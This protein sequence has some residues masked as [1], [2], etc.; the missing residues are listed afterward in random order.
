MSKKKKEHYVPQGY[1][2]NWCI[3]GSKQVNVFDKEKDEIRTNSIEDIASENYFYDLNLEG[4][5]S[6]EE[7]KFYNLEGVD[8]SRIDDK[9]YIENYFANHIEG[10]FKTLLEKLIFRSR[11]MS[12]WKIR[13]CSFIKKKDVRSFSV[14]MALQYIR[15][16]DVRNSIE[17]LADLLQ[18]ALTDQGAPQSMI[19]KYGSISKKEVK[20]VHG[21]MI[22]DSKEISKIANTF[23]DHIWL[24]LKNN[25]KKPFF[26]SDNPIGTTEHIK[27][28][29]MS[30]GGLS[31][32]GVEVFF[33][34]APDLM[35]I[36]LEKTHHS[37]FASKN[38]HIIEIDEP[39]IVEDYNSRC[40]MNSSRCI[41]SQTNDFSIIERMKNI[42]PNI[43]HL[44]KSILTWGGKTYTPSDK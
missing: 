7:I 44:P 18:Q 4:V 1:L 29:Y 14:F 34:L 35:L 17:E 32:K 27:H 9:Q 24:L 13:H 28:P 2:E 8:L 23:A 20:Y 3:P 12:P 5:L 31:A 33:P 36:L 10:A 26:T 21:R 19:E 15:V 25:T 42:N 6:K 39:E 22:F 41:F 43:L 37:I 30:M 40:V 38:H 16:K 11:A